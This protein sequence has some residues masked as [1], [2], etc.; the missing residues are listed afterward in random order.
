MDSFK[1]IKPADERVD[2]L[3]IS[4]YKNSENLKN[5]IKAIT[6]PIQ[7]IVPVSGEAIKSRQIKSATGYS[8]D[9]IGKTVGEGRIIVGAAA[10]EYFGFNKAP[11]ALGLDVGIFFSY[12]D[13]TTG[14]LVLT[15]MQYR[16]LIRARILKNTS[17][18]RREDVLKYCELLI[19]READIEITSG[20]CTTDIFFKEALQPQDKLLLAVRVSSIVAVGVKV[21]LRDINGIIEVF[22]DTTT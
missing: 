20:V 15:D 16:N 1:S 8:L 10:L 11:A 4:Q 6:R 7:S 19:G 5:Y 14:D 9:K 18:G 2:E 21:T 13:A 12:G 22:H 17:G 3:I